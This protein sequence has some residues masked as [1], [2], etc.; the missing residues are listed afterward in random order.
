MLK[1]FA[2]KNWRAEFD[3]RVEHFLNSYMK[4]ASSGFDYQNGESLFRRATFELH[5]IC[6]GHFLRSDYNVTPLVQFEACI[7]AIAELIEENV[8]IVRPEDDGWQ[9]DPEL[10]RAS[11]GGTNTRTALRRRIDRAKALFSGAA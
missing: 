6:G 8:R 2:Y 11:M 4:L 5:Q 1:F 3:G 7:V 10:K 9:D